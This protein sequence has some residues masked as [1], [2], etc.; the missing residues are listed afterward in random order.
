LKKAE[1]DK[2]ERMD[3]ETGKFLVPKNQN[4]DDIEG[5]I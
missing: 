3:W 5:E 2:D 4:D 1:T